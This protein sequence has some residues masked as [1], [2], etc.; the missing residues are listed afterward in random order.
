MVWPHSS[1][2]RM[3]GYQY[4]YGKHT[5]TAN[6]FLGSTGFTITWF[7]GISIATEL[8]KHCDNG[9]AKQTH[10]PCTNTGEPCVVPK[11][12]YHYYKS[13]SSLPAY[14]ESYAQSL[15]HIR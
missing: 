4:L 14:K 5:S 7:Y 11:L 6:I 12:L 15:I 2:R 13:A 1:Y 9:I 8:P 3:H 10:S